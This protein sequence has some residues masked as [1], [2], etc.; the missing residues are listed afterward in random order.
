M[1]G[2]SWCV[3]KAVLRSRDAAVCSEC[4]RQSGPYCFRQAAESVACGSPLGNALIT[5]SQQSHQDGP[6]AKDTSF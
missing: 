3:A 1:V 4:Q 2:G 6:M 5:L